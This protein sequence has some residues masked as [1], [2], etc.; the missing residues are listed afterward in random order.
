MLFRQY[1]D[2]SESPDGSMLAV[3]GFIGPDSVWDKLESGWL[4]SLPRS[5]SYFHATDCFSGN[6]E[7][8]P[9]YGFD[10][11]VRIALLD[12]LTDL[13][14]E[15]NLKLICR[16]IDVVAYKRHARKP[17]RN[18]F[19]VNK[20]VAPFEWAVQS[21]CR[22]FMPTPGFPLGA[23][24]GDV[25]ALFFEENDFLQT[26]LDAVDRMRS[27]QNIWWRNRIGEATHGTKTSIPLLQVADLG[28]FLGGKFITGTP[29]GKIAWRPYYDKLERAGKLW[30]KPTKLTKDDLA[31]FAGLHEA[32]EREAREGKHYWDDV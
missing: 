6:S 27:D 1:L 28:V 4:D 21:A 19:L 29:P 25:C 16:G 26:A 22:D 10:I 12:Q 2:E 18:E 3:G 23:E 13:I 32:L 9:K 15:S 31:V 7:F 20:Y 24:T 11:P 14:C 30:N 5:V 8:E 17:T